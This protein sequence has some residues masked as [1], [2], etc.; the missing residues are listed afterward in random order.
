M[1]NVR[2]YTDKQLLDRASKVEGFRG[3]PIGIFAIGVRSSEDEPDRF[4]DKMYIFQNAGGTIHFLKVIP[5]TTNSGTYGLLNFRKWNRKGTAVLCADMWHN[6]MW[7]EGK[8][9]GRMRAWVQV[10]DC[11]YTRD[12]NLNK[13]SE[14]YGKR[15]VGKIGINFHTVSYK[16]VDKILERIGLWGVGCQVCPDVKKYYETLDLKPKWQQR[17]SYCLLNEFDPC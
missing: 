10:G 3:F 16:I 2:S 14:E 1:T 15:Y 12:N 17:I 6:D 9:K 7:Q 5:I 11:T 13:K 4:D 8:H